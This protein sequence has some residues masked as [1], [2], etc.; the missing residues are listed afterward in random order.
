MNI[1]GEIILANVILN[2]QNCRMIHSIESEKFKVISS[3]LQS[4]MNKGVT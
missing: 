3:L 1:F 2:K 4:A